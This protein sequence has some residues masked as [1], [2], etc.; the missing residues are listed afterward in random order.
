MPRK[1]APKTDIVVPLPPAATKAKQAGL[2]LLR[3][4]DA[5]VGS[6]AVETADDYTTASE[7]LA[8]VQ[9]ARH[10]W[11][12]KMRPIIDP[13]RQLT[14]ALYALNREIDGPLERHEKH[15]KQLMKD[16][17]L[18]EARLIQAAREEQ[19]RLQREAEERARKAE[20]AKTKPAQQRLQQE[21]QSLQTLADQ[22][23]EEAAPLKVATSST[24]TKRRWRCTN[25]MAVVK[26][27]AAGTIPMETLMLDERSLNSLSPDDVAQWDGFEAFD[28]VIITGARR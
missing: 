7:I 14:D 8:M 10:T 28:D 3:P 4:L 17:K 5:E 6:L 20:A 26:G 21:A 13:L 24:R 22:V 15:V 19:Q 25:F 18:E 9:D 2:A 23:G 27:V 12:E 1:I 11:A 16:Y